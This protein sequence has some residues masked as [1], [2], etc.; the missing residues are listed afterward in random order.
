MKRIINVIFITVIVLQNS[1]NKEPP[2]SFVSEDIINS[3]T[4]KITLVVFLM[5]PPSDTTYVINENEHIYFSFYT[6][7]VGLPPPFSSD[8]VRVTYDDSISIM[9][10]RT[11]VQTASRSILNEDSWSGG[12]IEEYRYEWEYIFT[13]AD[14]MEAVENQ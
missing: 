3:S 12:K 14:Y 1:C 9:H 8:S 4:H 11:A 2:D 10:Y 6:R 7:T 13:N 5:K